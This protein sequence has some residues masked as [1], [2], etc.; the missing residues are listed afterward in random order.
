MARVSAASGRSSLANLDLALDLATE[1]QIDAIVFGPF[2]TAAFHAAGMGHTDQLHYMAARLGV[3]GLASELNALDGLWTSRV[4]SHIALRE[5]ADSITEERIAE[6]VTLIDRMLRRTGLR[7]PRMAVAALNPHAGDGGNLGRDEIDV[8][9]PAVEA[10]ARQQFAIDGPLPSDKVFLKAKRGEIDAGHHVSRPG[11]DRAELMGFDRGVTML[12][13]LPVPIATPARG[14]A[15]D[16]AG[17]GVADAGAMRAALAMACDMVEHW[18]A[19][20]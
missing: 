9:R 4:T 1:G 2:N 3:R 10:L 6:A 15:F 17:R 5:V 13:G 14:T 11:P 18:S 8:I 19:A 7:R 16:I 20:P 12:G